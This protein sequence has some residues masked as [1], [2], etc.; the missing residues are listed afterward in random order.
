MAFALSYYMR[1]ISHI[2]QIDA[3]DAEVF[4]VSIVRLYDS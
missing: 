3:E 1:V 2:L 4:I